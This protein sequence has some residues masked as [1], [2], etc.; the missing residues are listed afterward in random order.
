MLEYRLAY[1]R[2]FQ[3][4][5]DKSQGAAEGVILHYINNNLVNPENPKRVDANLI[6]PAAHDPP[7]GDEVSIDG[8]YQSLAKIAETCCQTGNILI[9]GRLVEGT[10]TP[11]G[12]S[13]AIEITVGTDRSQH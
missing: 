12:W 13:V 1:P 5:H 3:M 10:G 8:R 2:Q 11:M 7:L 6:V 9:R 4:G